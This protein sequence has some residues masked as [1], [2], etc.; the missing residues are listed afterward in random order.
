MTEIP[1]P[2]KSALADSYEIEDEIGLGGMATV[3]L[4]RDLKHDRKVAVRSRPVAAM[5]E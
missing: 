5:S 3:Y 4:A 2:L 1:A